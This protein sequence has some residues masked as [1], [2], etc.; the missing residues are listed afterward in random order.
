MV[1]KED[2]ILAFN[3]GRGYSKHGQR[4]AAVRLHGGK[5][6]FVDIDRGL[7]YVTTV[8]TSKE[9]SE[10]FVMHCYD[11]NLT[12]HLSEHL[13]YPEDLREAA[14]RLKT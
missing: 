12:E 2:A 11:N 3:T 6:A 13:C 5:V 14:G 8:T 4:I 9:V 10:E 1:S 7:Q